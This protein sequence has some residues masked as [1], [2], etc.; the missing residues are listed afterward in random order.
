MASPFF[1]I[2]TDV[3][4]RTAGITLSSNAKTHFP[5]HGATLLSAVARLSKYA[6]YTV[7]FFRIGID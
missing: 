3:R 2:R 1:L 7:L 5:V 6:V 4:R